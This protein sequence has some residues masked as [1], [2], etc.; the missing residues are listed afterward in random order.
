MASRKPVAV[1]GA[2]PY[3]LSV[4]A[5]LRASGIATEIFGSPFSFWRSMPAG[6]ALKSPWSASS[7]SDP[8]DRFTLDAFVEASGID[9][10]E[11]IPLELFLQYGDWFTERAVGTVDLTRVACV[12]ESGAG[13]VVSLED[14]RELAASRVVIATGIA[15]FPKVPDFAHGLPRALVRHSGE[16]LDFSLYAGMR[17]GVIGAGQSALEAAVFLHEAGAEVEVISRG[18]IRWINRRLY[19]RGGITR[20]VFYPPADVGPLGLNWLVTIPSLF[21]LIPTRQRTALTH[22]AIRPAGAKWLQPRFAPEIRTTTQT[23]VE[24]VTVK[25]QGLEVVTSDGVTRRLDR[26]VLGTGYRPEISRIPILH[27]HLR[28]KVKQSGGNPL[29]DRR[30]QSSI[31]GL[32]F[33]GALAGHTFGPLCRFVA[34]AGVA[35]RAVTRAAS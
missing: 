17:V 20:K 2:G 24:K 27:E 28:R 25:G 7:L 3:G 14:G 12:Q 35:A 19:E 15:G 8:K 18:P 23:R 33:V 26:V 6:M 34:G 21:R 13:F 22:R 30:F 31:A 4:A 10:Q 9:R 29:L 16:P 5:H 32:H 1:V 11:P